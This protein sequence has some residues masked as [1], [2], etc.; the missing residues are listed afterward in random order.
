VAWLPSGVFFI[1]GFK[2]RKGELCQING[3][4]KTAKYAL[5]KIGYTEQKV[6]KHVCD[7]HEREIAREN[8]MRA[9][10]LK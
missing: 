9:G 7:G 10:I 3:C 6:W 5:Y 2:M 1:G 4:K 8:L